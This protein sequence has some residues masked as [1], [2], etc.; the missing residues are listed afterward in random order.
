MIRKLFPPLIVGTMLLFIG[1]ALVT[2]GI[3]NWA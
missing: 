2:S 1:A 3:T